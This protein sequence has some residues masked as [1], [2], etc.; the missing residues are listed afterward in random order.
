M[1]DCK[2]LGPVGDS[3]LLLSGL[4]FAIIVAQQDDAAYL[5]RKSDLWQSARAHARPG[6]NPVQLGKGGCGFESFSQRYSLADVPVRPGGTNGLAKD[7][8]C[9]A[10]RGYRINEQSL[11]R[12]QPV[13]QMHADDKCRLEYC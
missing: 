7:D 12:C 11:D 10:A 13:A 2:P 6:G 8:L 3:G 5:R 4:A 1:F 9:G